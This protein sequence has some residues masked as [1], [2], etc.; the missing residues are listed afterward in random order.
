MLP[1]FRCCP[2]CPRGRARSRWLRLR[3]GDLKAD[4]FVVALARVEGAAV[5]NEENIARELNARPKLPNLCE[6][7]DVRSLT[8]LEFTREHGWTF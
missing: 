5:V 1:L 8:L 7:F 3:P 2:E 4:P 6:W